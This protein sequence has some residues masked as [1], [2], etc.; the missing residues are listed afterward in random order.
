MGHA[1]AGIQR[2]KDLGHQARTEEHGVRY[3]C[4]NLDCTRQREEG[5]RR[6]LLGKLCFLIKIPADACLH[7]QEATK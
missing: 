6:P 4:A 5:Q 2:R 7:V 1:N 3:N